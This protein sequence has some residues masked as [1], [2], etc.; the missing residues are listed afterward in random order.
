MSDLRLP[1]LNKVY[2]AGRLTRDPDLKFIG[3]GKAVCKL[4]LAV[5]RIYKT[6]D[7]EK[8][9]DTTFVD[10]TV[11]D[12]QAEYIGENFKK[13]RP[14]LVEGS[15]R[16]DSWE[17][18]QTGQKRTKLEVQAVRVQA[19]D[20]EDRAG[21]GGAPSSSSRPAASRGASSSYDDEP[22]AEDDIPF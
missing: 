12:R 11:W 22:P 17:D 21:G 16:S 3:S 19:L 2:L 14:V 13:G 6:K 1:D 5:S 9:E 4:G 7:G 8:R 20:W 15:L 10:V 18:K